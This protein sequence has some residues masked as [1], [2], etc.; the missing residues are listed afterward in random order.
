MEIKTFPLGPLETNCFM[1]I[2][3]K[4]AVV[5]D[6]GGAPDPLLKEL[7]QNGLTLTH[8]LNTHFHFDHIY[9]NKALAEA[10]GAPIL[11]PQGD[12]ELLSTEV[13]GG[14]FM[15]LPKVAP[16]TFDPI[17]LGETLFMGLPCSVLPTPGHSPASVSYYFPTALAVFVGDLL[18][19]RSIGRTD[20]PGGSLETLQQSVRERIF[21]LPENVA[22]YPG[23]GAKT[24]VGEEKTHN[25]YFSSFGI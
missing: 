12:E 21:T 15:G 8:I 20:F 2:E 7:E 25:P 4:E 3:G 5:V 18:F 10:T 24:T 14:G 1:L 19:Q 6:P 17:E 13:G 22:V 23:H 11:A 9:G 16:F